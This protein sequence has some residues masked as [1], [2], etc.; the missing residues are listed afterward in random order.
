MDVAYKFSGTQ[1]TFALAK[2]GEDGLTFAK[3]LIY[4]GDF[5][6]DLPS[7]EKQH[8]SVDESL[9]HHWVRTGNTMLSQ[10]MKIP[11]PKEHSL[12]VEDNRAETLE[13]T[14]RKNEDG[15]LALFCTMKFRDAEAA[16]LAKTASVSIWVPPEI[17]N[18]ATKET[19]H[20]PIAHIA[21]TDYPVIPKLGEFETVALSIYGGKDMSLANLASS[22]GITGDAAKD[23]ASISGA[24]LSLV[25]GLRTELDDLKKKT[26]AP[27]PPEKKP[28]E[29]KPE[30]AASQIGLLRDNRE[31]KIANLVRDNK[32]T[33]AVAK[34]LT[35]E[36]CTDDAL[37]LGYEHPQIFDGI[38]SALSKN[39]PVLKTGEQSGPQTLTLSQADVLN[40][41]KNPLLA[42]AER[43]CETSVN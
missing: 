17:T 11:W 34:E 16:K 25:K 28:E 20:R 43:R 33:P 13:F 4:T 27:K 5:V 12:D 3:E 14:A 40:K 2:P 24:I 38:I 1:T 37:K 9:I 42:D 35:A 19:F 6:R 32:I 15:K 36:H 21:L 39:D 7:G 41:D 22:L 26:P 18:A 23:D 30:I 31:M 8:F 10:G 29:K